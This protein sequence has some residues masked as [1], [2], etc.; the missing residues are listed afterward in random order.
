MSTVQD[1]KHPS[2]YGFGFDEFMATA[3]F[4]RFPTWYVERCLL[5]RGVKQPLPATE[6]AE[7]P[8]ELYTFSRQAA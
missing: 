2:R 7:P 6:T 5:P 8:V 4:D 1:N 3:N